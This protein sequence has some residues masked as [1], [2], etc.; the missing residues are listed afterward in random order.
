MWNLLKSLHWLGNDGEKLAS[1][2]KQTIFFYYEYV[3]YAQKLLKH[4]H[5]SLNIFIRKIEIFC[6]ALDFR[7]SIIH[8]SFWIVN[9]LVVVVNIVA[10][11]FPGTVHL[12]CAW[13]IKYVFAKSIALKNHV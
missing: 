8:V 6:F 4:I 5:E 13:T 2:H 12:K 11:A 7:Y 3:W 1:L 10:V 9:V